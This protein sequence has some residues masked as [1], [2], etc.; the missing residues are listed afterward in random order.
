[1]SKKDIIHD[2]MSPKL[3]SYNI[4]SRKFQKSKAKFKGNPSKSDYKTLM[5]REQ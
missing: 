2:G 3:A 1:M 4:T 5:C